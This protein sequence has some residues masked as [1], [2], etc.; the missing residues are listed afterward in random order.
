MPKYRGELRSPSSDIGEAAAFN[1]LEVMD[2][3]KEAEVGDE[4]SASGKRKRMRSRKYNNMGPIKRRRFFQDDSYISARSRMPESSRAELEI[5]SQDLLKNI[6]FLAAKYYDNRGLLENTAK[7]YRDMRRQQKRGQTS[8]SHSELTPDASQSASNPG[9]SDIAPVVVE[10]QGTQRGRVSRDMYRVLD[11][12]ALLAIGILAQEMVKKL[13]SSKR[14]GPPQPIAD[15]DEPVD[16]GEGEQLELSV[17]ASDCFEDQGSADEVV[18]EGTE[19]E[20]DEIEWEDE[21]E[22]Q[23]TG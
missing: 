17:P 15:E 7:R 18:S 1:E 3:D 23:G 9:P 21:S 5:P 14:G 2:E 12:S 8:R 22:S 19:E 6:H 10:D 4:D 16:P 20:T 13:V 11:G